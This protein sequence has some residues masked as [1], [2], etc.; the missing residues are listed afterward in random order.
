VVA[1]GDRRRLGVI[2]AALLWGALRDRFEAAEGP[3]GQT[4]MVWALR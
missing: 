1:D 3:A 2:D 4:V